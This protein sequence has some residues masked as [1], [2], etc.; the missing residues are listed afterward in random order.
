MSLLIAIIVLGIL[1]VVHEFGHFL[2]AKLFKVGVL[3]YSVGFGKKIFQ[4][5]K[6]ETWYSL[7]LIPLG[8]Y[9]SMAGEDPYTVYGKEH[10]KELEK[11]FEKDCENNKENN[12]EDNKED[13]KSKENKNKENENK[14]NKE[15]EEQSLIPSFYDE[16][17]IKLLKDESRWFLNK[18]VWKKFLIVLA[19]PFAN[20]LFAFLVGIFVVYFWGID[21]PVNKPIIGE[22][23]PDY[24]AEKAGIKPNDKILLINNKKPKTWEDVSK[25]IGRSK[26]GEAKIVLERNEN[27]IKKVKTLS[28]VAIKDSPELEA[29]IGEENLGNKLKIGIMPSLE[30]KKVPLSLTPLYSLSKLAS[31]T[32]MTYR[33]FKGMIT[34]SISAKHLGGP[35]EIVN[36]TA[37]VSKR[38]FDK[39]LDLMIFISMSLAIM[40]LL[41]IPILDGG[42]LMFFTIEFFIR[43]PVPL[44][45]Q[46]SAGQL[47]I[48][49]LFTLMIFA[50]GNDI[51]RLFK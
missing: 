26:D 11:E 22:V 27:G 31:I 1:V 49:I 28:L 39:L 17:S 46:A 23:V 8:G 33:G 14:E 48:L 10:K 2:I 43:R 45:V 24:P 9:V 7:R 4:V 6:G 20:I 25:Y 35:I 34:G 30:A 15:N 19:G 51:F 42:H 38:G 13:S 41:P 32:V 29:I 44:K 36:T 50:T 40:N 16:D 12:K 3:E 37:K 47:G 5:K 18:P 21:V